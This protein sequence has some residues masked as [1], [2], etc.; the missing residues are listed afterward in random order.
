MSRYM[1]TSLRVAT[2]V[3]DSL[4]T[5]RV[6]IRDQHSMLNQF[7]QISQVKAM[8]QSAELTMLYFASQ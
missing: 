4:V 3:P 7:T 2:G 8:R 1:L 5:G 6:R